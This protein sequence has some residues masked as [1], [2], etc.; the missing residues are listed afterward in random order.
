M[1]CGR[2]NPF[3]FEERATLCCTTSSVLSMKLAAYLS[4]ALLYCKLPEAKV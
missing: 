3:W 2:L 1:S 4:W